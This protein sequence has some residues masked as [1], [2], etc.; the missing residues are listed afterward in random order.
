GDHPDARNHPAFAAIGKTTEPRVSVALFTALRR[1]RSDLPG[2]EELALALASHPDP[3]LARA[4]LGFL[5]DR[6][7]VGTALAALDLEDRREQWAGAL[8]LLGSLRRPE[9]VEGLIVRLRRTG[10]PE[11]RRLGLEALCRLCSMETDGAELPS[12]AEMSADD[13]GAASS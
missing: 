4:A 8:T 2:A 12:A 9:V 6:E 5:R 13:L 10:D 3:G 1:S 7:A 11:W